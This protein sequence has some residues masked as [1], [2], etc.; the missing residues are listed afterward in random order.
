MVLS[1]NIP[2]EAAAVLMPD[3]QPPEKALG[4]WIAALRE[5]FEETGILLAR[6]SDGRL[7]EPTRAEKIQVAAQRQA[8]LQG[9]A[10]FATVMH[11]LE[12]MLA[13]DLLVYFAHWITPET[14][15]IRFSTRFFLARVPS[16]LQAEPDQVEVVEQLW[17]TPD[18]AIQ[19]HVDGEMKMLNVT[20]KIL[21]TLSPFSSAE[22]AVKKLLYEPVETVLPKP[23]VQ[24]DGTTRMLYPGDEGY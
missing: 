16:V 21:E 23:V 8:L 9:T 20:V 11:D 15:P 13:T 24:A 18:E 10:P 19:R 17:I 7:W 4:Y 14:L 12:R 5:T 3:E 2:P 6:Y 22:E 1:H